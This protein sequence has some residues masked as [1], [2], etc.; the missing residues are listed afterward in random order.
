MFEYK[1]TKQGV[2][3]LSS[4]RRHSGARV[5]IPDNRI[6]SPQVFKL[7]VSYNLGL[8]YDFHGQGTEEELEPLIQAYEKKM[9]RWYTE[10][11]DGEKQVTHISGIHQKVLALLKSL[12]YGEEDCGIC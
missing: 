10:A 6:A 4:T 9:L 8:S 5:F 12:H 2:R 3:D 11:V 7:F 1:M